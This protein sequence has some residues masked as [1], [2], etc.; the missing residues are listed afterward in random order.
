[1]KFGVGQALARK[2]D[3]PLLRGAGRYVADYRAGT[4]RC[5]P[6]WCARRMRMRA[7]RIGDRRAGARDARRAAGPDRR[8]HRRPRPDAD[9]GRAFRRR[10]SIVPPYP[11][12]AH[13]DGPPCRR[14]GRLR[15]R[16][17]ARAGARR[18]RGDRD[19][20][21]AAAACGRRGGR[22]GKAARRRSGR[23]GRA[24]SRSR[25]RSA[26]RRRPRRRSRTPR[27][28]SRVKLVNQRLVTNYIDTRGVIAE[29]D[30][31]RD[32]YTLTLGSQG[33]HIIRDIICGE[34]L[35]SAARQDARHHARCRRRLRHQAVPLS[36][37][38]AGRGR[39]AKAPAS[40]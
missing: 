39:G 14:R 10:R 33:S 21:G 1:M 18:R 20:L 12:L 36:R 3:D 25:R 32:H 23:T 19:R 38:C 29:Y 27:A 16:R 11:M 7:S 6:W 40:R 8:R 22:A 13:D 30:R 28:W 31:R 9:A 15:R 2:E 34:V 5:M 4:A 26:T 37:I 17:Y 35:K 24:I